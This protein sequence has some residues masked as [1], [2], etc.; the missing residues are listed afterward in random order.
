MANR[1]KIKLSYKLYYV[2]IKTKILLIG[3][4]YYRQIFLLSIV[5]IIFIQKLMTVKQNFSF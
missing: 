1:I 2:M 5:I 3:N 4:D